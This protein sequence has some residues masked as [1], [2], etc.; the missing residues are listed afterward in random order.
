[1]KETSYYDIMFGLTK[2]SKWYIEDWSPI[3]RYSSTKVFLK[4]DRI[5]HLWL[6]IAEFSS[7][8]SFTAE[9]TTQMVYKTHKE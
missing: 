5:I 7:P 2:E 9:C 8:Y 4:D 3:D 6:E 1:M